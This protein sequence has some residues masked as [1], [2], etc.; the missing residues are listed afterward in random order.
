MQYNAIKTCVSR[1]CTVVNC[2]IK[3]DSR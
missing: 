2:W 3:S 1:T